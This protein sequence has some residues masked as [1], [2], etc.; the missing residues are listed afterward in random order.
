MATEE[1]VLQ[2]MIGKLTGIGRC[3]GME[4]NVGEK[5]KVMKISRQLFPVKLM[6]DQ[7]QL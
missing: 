6:T 3:Y 2:D 1:M 7:K 5:T 4:I